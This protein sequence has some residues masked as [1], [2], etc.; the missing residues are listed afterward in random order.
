MQ[1]KIMNNIENN[2]I[3]CHGEGC[4][5]SIPATIL[6]TIT[7]QL[8]SN[9]EIGIWHNQEINNAYFCPTCSVHYGF[10]EDNINCIKLDKNIVGSSGL[11]YASKDEIVKVISDQGTHFICMKKRSIDKIRF[12]VFKNKNNVKTI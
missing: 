3:S 5:N 7:N 10:E 4:T 2:I 12:V 11:K 9:P 1:F 8:T 6:D